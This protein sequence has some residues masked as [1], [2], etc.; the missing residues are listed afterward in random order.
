MSGEITTI[1]VSAAVAC[2]SA[3]LGAW[4]NSVMLHRKYK[5]EVDSLKEELRNKQVETKGH[6]LENVRKANE[7]LMET[8][9]LPLQK[10]IKSLRNETGKLRKA[11]E[12]IPSCPHAGD[13]PVS[14]ELLDTEANA[15]E[16]GSEGGK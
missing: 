2:V 8:V 6:E 7:M 11:I 3:P 4:I 9:V 14:R 15:Q 1:I 5:I 10:E 13:C 16:R 12:K